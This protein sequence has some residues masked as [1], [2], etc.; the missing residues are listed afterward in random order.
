M[1]IFFLFCFIFIINEDK[2]SGDMILMYKRGGGLFFLLF[3]CSKCL[4]LKWVYELNGFFES[5]DKI[6]FRLVKIISS[7]YMY[8]FVIKVVI[9]ICIIMYNLVG[10]FDIKDGRFFNKL[11]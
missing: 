3:I 2:S 10:F 11:R 7:M 6:F 8:K 1:I 9:Y 5:L 4:Y